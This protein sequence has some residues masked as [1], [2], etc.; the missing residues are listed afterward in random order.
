M[1]SETDI[2]HLYSDSG[3]LVISDIVTIFLQFQYCSR[4]LSKNRSQLFDTYLLIVLCPV[5]A[6]QDRG[7]PEQLR[8]GPDGGEQRDPGVCHPGQPGAGGGL[9]EGGRQ[10]DHHRQEH[11]RYDQQ[12]QDV[13]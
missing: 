4:I 5:S 6:A 2:T 9:A 8:H 1:F 10:G 12:H 11:H 13:E 7:Q 3:H